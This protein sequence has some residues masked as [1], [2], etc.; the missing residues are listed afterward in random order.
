MALVAAVVVQRGHTLKPL[1]VLA[2]TRYGVLGA[3]SRLR[4]LQYF[5]A[6]QAAGIQVKW[7]ALFGDA[8]LGGR[9]KRGQYGV[10]VALAAFGARIQIMIKRRNFDLVWIEKEALPYLPL[11]LE[12][13]LLSGAPYV[14][15]YDDA[16][17]HNYDFHRSLL[18]RRLY[19]KRLDG[20]M[21]K[22]ALVVCGNSYLA[23]RAASADAARVEQLPTVID[24]NRYTLQSR[25]Q[26]I[27]DVHD[28]VQDALQEHVPRIVWIGS[29]S[30]SKYLALLA[31]PLQALAQAMPFVL[32][33]IGAQFALPGVQVECVPWSEAT[34][35]GDI[36]A[37]DVGVMP[38]QDTAWERGKCGYKLIQYMACGLPVVASDVGVN[39]EIVQAGVNGYLARNTDE[40]LN[41]LKSLISDAAARHQ[42]G[43][44]GRQRVEDVYCI[45]KTGPV[46]AQWL[47]KAAGKS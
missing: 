5:P 45:Q 1:R 17:F 12:L 3:S 14:L 7:Q 34:E 29:P 35:V 28:P 9:Y 43:I 2:L 37:C 42:F 32:R 10:G 6:L 27:S 31:E 4:F 18:V 41:A 13:A 16:V 11:W 39:S 33:I 26:F 47:A 22:A 23:Q 19:G 25:A 40:W 36:A 24:L 38:L 15:D 21:A 8:A 44:S 20:L 46:L 30:T